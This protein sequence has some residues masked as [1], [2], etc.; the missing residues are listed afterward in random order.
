MSLLRCHRVFVIASR[1]G[2]IGGTD[3]TEACAQSHLSALRA[4]VAAPRGS[5]GACREGTRDVTS[6][7]SHNRHLGPCSLLLLPPPCLSSL[8]SLYAPRPSVMNSR[9]STCLRRLAR[10]PATAPAHPRGPVAP[11]QI[12]APPWSSRVQVR[13]MAGPA[14]PTEMRF[15]ECPAA[16]EGREAGWG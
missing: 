8:D 10:S 4:G 11:R 1:Q 7:I 5:A 16:R 6:F 14:P 3:G 13:A 9:A 12:A 2:W 15:S